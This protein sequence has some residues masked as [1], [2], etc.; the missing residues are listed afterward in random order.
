MKEVK[1]YIK[2][3]QSA[4]LA[5]LFEYLKIPSVSTDPAYKEKV[6]EAAFFTKELLEKAGAENAQVISTEGHPLVYAEKII[7]DTLPT[8]LVYG[9]FDVQPAD[10]VAEWESDPFKPEVRDDKIFARGA[11][12]DK[13][14][15]HMSIKAFEA[16]S[17]TQKL[18]CNVKFLLE[19]E[20]E[21][22]SPNIAEYI[23]ENKERLKAD[24]VLVTDTALIDKDTPTLTTSLRGMANIEIEVRSLK[25]D[26]HS[27]V[28]GGAVHNPIHVLSKLLGDL[29]D[30]DFKIKIP[31]F[32]DNVDD[33]SQDDRDLHTK[34]STT[35]SE[36]T[37]H[38]CCKEGVCEAGFNQYE[39][40]TIRPSIDV[41]GIYGGYTGEGQKS[42]IP[43]KAVAKVSIRLVS[44]QKP[45][46]IIELIEN[47]IKENVPKT[48]EVSVKK[49]ATNDYGVGDPVMLQTNSDEY[50][51]AKQAFAKTY[52]NEMIPMWCGGSIPVVSV[53]KKL[54]NTTSVLIGFGLETDNI[55]APN[56]HFHLENYFK[57]IETLAWFYETYAKTKT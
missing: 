14:Q 21:I 3:N 5:E 43:E 8:V 16:L 40:A 22:G 11:S 29:E 56:E 55:H 53:F 51:A 28:Y 48:V 19:G 54:L 39:S 42:I 1:K 26:A 45:N 24:T 10:P 34:P 4:F 38:I 46:E 15:L 20:E 7:S 33:I 9:H 52:S 35:F 18:Q 6:Q 12:D 37:K 23:A 49:A 30:E 17:K 44:N 41:N 32:Y 27:G 25:R 50:N 31:G 13:G 2:D 57:G 36:A 47:Y